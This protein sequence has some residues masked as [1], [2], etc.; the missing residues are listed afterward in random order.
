MARIEIEVKYNVDTEVAEI[1]TSAEKYANMNEDKDQVR[2]VIES[3]LQAAFEDGKNFQKKN[4]N[5]DNIGLG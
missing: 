3:K 1:L 5:L 2:R 4:G